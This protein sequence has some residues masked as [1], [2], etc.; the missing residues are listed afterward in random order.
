[1]KISRNRLMLIYAQWSLISKWQGVSSVIA[2][3]QLRAIGQT[4]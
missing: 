1:V 4:C 2:W 3:V